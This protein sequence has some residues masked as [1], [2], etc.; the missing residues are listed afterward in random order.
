ME[1]LQLKDNFAGRTLIL[2]TLAML[3]IGMVM[4]HSAVAS[5]GQPGAWYARVEVRHSVFAMASALV[6]TTFWM[7]DYRLLLKGRRLP[8]LP[9]VLLVIALICGALV[10]VKGVGREVGGQYRWIRLGPDKY[11]IGFQPSELIKLALIVFLAAWLSRKTPEH[12]RSFW[13]TFGPAACLMGICV[14][15]VITEDFGTAVLIGTTACLTLLLAGVPLWHFLVMIPPAA[16]GFWLLVVQNPH[17]WARIT[18]FLDPWSQTNPSAYQPRQSLLAILSG[19]WTGKGLG[20]G[21]MKQGFLPED[22]TDFVFAVLAEETGFVGCMLLMALIVVWLYASYK[23]AMRAGDGFGRL[24]AGTLG[25]AI[26]LQALLHIAVNLVVAPPTGV[27]LPFISAGG[28]ALV[29]MGAAAS[30]IVS[31]SARPGR[32]LEGAPE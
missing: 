27:S 1:R 28:T 32:E 15:L 11:S 17:R 21:M 20:R 24:L 19:G 10:Y 4:V 29:I 14:G 12:L 6:L 7:F 2:A 23:A 18:A 13:R 30:L 16:G 22:S 3:A 9:C 8:L 26:A 5:V 25:F 31:V